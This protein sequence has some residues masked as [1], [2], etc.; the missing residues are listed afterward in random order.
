MIRRPPRSTRTDTLFPYTTLCR[1]DK[2]G[3]DAAD[4]S[5][6]FFDDVF[7]PGDNVLGGEEG[8]GFYQLMGE[9][10]QE[11]LVIAVGTMKMIEKA[12]DTTVE[13][14][15]QRKAF[16]QTIWDFQNTQFVLADLKARRSEE[17]RVGKECVST[18]RTR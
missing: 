13:Y 5:E 9:L 16:A 11:R 7:V 14:V 17:R 15:K 12:L 8:K 1:S 18:W 3:M 10:P 4:T 2:I 6:L